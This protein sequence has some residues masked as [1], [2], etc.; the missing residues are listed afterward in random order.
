MNDAF[1]LCIILHSILIIRQM[2][3]FL[4]YAKYYINIDQKLW[5]YNMKALIFVLSTTVGNIVY[6]CQPYC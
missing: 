5:F 6:S 1:L 3:L 4:F 2:M